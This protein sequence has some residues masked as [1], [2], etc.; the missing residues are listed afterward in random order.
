M[1]IPPIKVPPKIVPTAKGV[2]PNVDLYKAPEIL[3]HNIFFCKFEKFANSSSNN[4][5][6]VLPVK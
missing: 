5:F 3:P 4:K 2:T 1:V 6:R